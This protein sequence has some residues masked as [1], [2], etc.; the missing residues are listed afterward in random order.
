MFEYYFLYDMNVSKILLYI[1]M[2]DITDLQ[3]SKALHFYIKIT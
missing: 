2:W 1:F 3:L